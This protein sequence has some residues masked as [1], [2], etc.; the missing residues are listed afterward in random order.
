MSVPHNS[1]QV[2]G[3]TRDR[4][5]EED[6]GEEESNGLPTIYFSHT[7]EP[8]KVS[9]FINRI[10][11]NAVNS[12]M[13]SVMLFESRKSMYY[14]SLSLSVSLSLRLQVRINTG[15]NTMLKF[16]ELKEQKQ[17]A[18]RKKKNG[19]SNGHSHHGLHNIT[20]PTDIY[21]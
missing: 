21:R 5:E 10:K 16:S 6:K 19:N 17:Q 14:N 13:F 9:V 8:K 4:E 11:L 18:K 3:T 12:Q 20:T 1:G 2:N 15:K 7:V